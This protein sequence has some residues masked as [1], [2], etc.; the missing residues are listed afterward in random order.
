MKK[1]LIA[2]DHA[3]IDLKAAIVTQLKADGYTVEDLGP[4]ST[5]SV[6]Y[7]DFANKVCEQI[8]PD[9][10][11]TLGVLVCGSGQGMAMRAN[12]FKHIRAALLHSDEIAKLAKEHN[13]ANV[14][15]MGSRFTTTEQANRWIKLFIEAKFSE[16]RHTNRVAKLGQNPSY[17]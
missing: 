1:I 2:G 11:E 10:T 3:A 7:P 17:C 6:D 15:C 8:K 9:D 14:I 16:G 12:K 4:F 13:N 5:E